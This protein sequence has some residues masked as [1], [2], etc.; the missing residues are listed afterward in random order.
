MRQR[1][2][3][4][5]AAHHSQ[6]FRRF[7]QAH[8]VQPRPPVGHGGRRLQILAEPLAQ[9]VQRAEQD[10]IGIRVFALRVVDHVQAVEQQVQ[11][12]IDFIERQR[13]IHAQLRRRGV[14]PQAAAKPDFRRQ[15]AHPVEQHAVIVRFIAFD[16]HQHR[17]RFIEAGQVPKVAV[18]PIGIV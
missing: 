1:A 7:E 16:Q 17:F 4:T 15:I 11:L 8:V 5:G 9:L 6:L 10:L 14:L 12:V 2:D 13:A 18:L 3:L